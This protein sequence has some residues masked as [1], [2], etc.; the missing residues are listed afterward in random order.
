VA[1]RSRNAPKLQRCRRPPAALASPELQNDSLDW[2]RQKE[3]GGR[4]MGIELPLAG[5]EKPRIAGL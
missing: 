2:R 1:S 4:E 5:T 3:R